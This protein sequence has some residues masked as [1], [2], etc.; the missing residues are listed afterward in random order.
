MISVKKKRKNNNVPTGNLVIIA[1]FLF[2]ALIIGRGAY[3]ALSTNIDGINIKEFS[4]SRT[5]RTDTLT[6]TRG[7]IYDVN[8]ETLAENVYSYTLIA[9]LDPDRTTNENNPQHVVDK[10]GTAQALSTVIDMSYEEIL[11][12]L[13][14]EGVYQTEFGKAGKSLNEIQ[15]DKILALGLPGIDFI[16]TQTRYYPNGNFLSYAIGYAK[17]DS[18]G[19]ITGEMGIEKQYDDILSG[20]DGYVTYQKDRN[21][22]KISGTDEIRVEAEDGDNVYLTVDSNIQLFVEQAI[23]ESAKQYAFDGVN[24]MVADAETG[25]ILASASYPSFDPNTRNDIVSY[26]DSNVSIGTEPGSTMKIYTY[27]AAMEA[28]KYNGNDT[29]LSGIYTAQDGTQIGDHDRAGWGVIT[30]DYGFA[31]SSNVAVANLVTKYIYRATLGNYFKKLGFGSKTGIELP[32]EA[33]GKISFQYETEVINASFGQG[34]LT[35]PIQNIKALTAIAN[36]GVLLQ[37]YIVDKIVD[38]STGEVTYQGERTELG[39][40]ASSSTVTKMKQLMHDV[41]DFGTGSIYAMEGYDLIAKTGTAQIASTDGSGYLTG[42]YDVIRGFAGIYPAENPKL[43]IYA[44]MTRPQSKSA[45]PLSMIIDQIIVNATQYYGIDTTVDDNEVVDPVVEN[46]M[47]SFI[48][49]TI[50]NATT[51]LTE[52]GVTPYV[53]G[54]GTKVVSQYP[55]E[56]TTIT[57]KEKVFLVTNDD[58]T[59]AMPNI[60]G[61]S[62]KEVK[63]FANLLKIPLTVTGNGYVT[64]Q[65]IPEGTILNQDSMLTITLE[66]KFQSSA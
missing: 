15:K 2:F 6:A 64:S 18:S 23:A 16:E 31:Q 46:L 43:I 7:K 35:T 40:V 9:Y 3:L 65:S 45:R 61:W 21:G 11:S 19:E 47:P 30:Y 28:G 62:L 52:M 1:S 32:N 27:M 48:N 25:A 57:N 56:G 13:N 17:T 58:T 24:I 63:A 51:T 60:T 59:I 8:G 44:T 50:N 22:Y 29:Y 39:Q 26:L 36:D 10:E 4:S 34:I 20:T 38:G 12:L 37:P 33:S 55:A 42:E 49:Q 53:L 14:K 66:V 5:T 41:V 54:N